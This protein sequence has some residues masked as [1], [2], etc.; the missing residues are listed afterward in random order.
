MANSKKEELIE[1]PGGKRVK[2]VPLTGADYFAFQDEVAKNPGNPLAGMPA[3]MM[4][5][6]VWESGAALTIDELMDAD[7]IGFEGVARLSEDLTPLFT[8][9]RPARTLSPLQK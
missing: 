2:R 4:K 5:R 8:A 7:G 6:Y 9:G 1:L 3:L